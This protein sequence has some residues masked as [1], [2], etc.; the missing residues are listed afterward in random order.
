[1]DTHPTSPRTGHQAQARVLASSCVDRK[2][3]QTI[4]DL[5]DKA[6]ASGQGVLKNARRTAV[7][8]VSFDGEW[9]C[10][11][12]FRASRSSE[13]LK[14][15]LRTSRAKRAWDGAARIEAAGVATPEPLALLER[16]DTHFVV[17]RFEGRAVALDQLVTERFFPPLE[18]EQLAA[19]RTL[20]GQLGAW[21][22]RVH[23][24]N[25]Y[26]DDWSPKNILVREM[27][28]GWRFFFVDLDSVDFRRRLSR[29]RRL[30][31]LSQLNDLP[32]CVSGADRMRFLRVYARGR[33]PFYTEDAARRIARATDARNELWRRRQA[34]HLRRAHKEHTT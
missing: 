21:L 34:K 10:V 32:A 24:S 28:D 18:T 23:D 12:E 17:T 2:A 8:R 6:L 33:P 15:R 30:K 7:T 3:A 1:M 29:R 5:H 16:G 19:K 20:I 25:I 31:N 9:L 11:K 22:R 4:L 13:R 27:D 14:D 26:H